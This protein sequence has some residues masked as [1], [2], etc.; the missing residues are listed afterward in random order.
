MHIIFTY[1]LVYMLFIYATL[2]H[3]TQY[4]I[5]LGTHKVNIERGVQFYLFLY[6]ISTLV[7]CPHSQNT[8][9]LQVYMYF[10]GFAIGYHM[11]C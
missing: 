4:A 2:F 3:T 11:K 6:V 5:K 1:K 7:V 10:N 9:L 8:S